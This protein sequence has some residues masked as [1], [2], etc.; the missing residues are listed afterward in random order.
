MRAVASI[1]L[2]LLAGCVASQV[3]RVSTRLTCQDYANAWAR[4]AN[5]RGIEAGVVWYGC[6]AGGGH[7]IC[8][9]IEPE[10]GD[11]VFVEPQGAY[12]VTL[13]AAEARSVCHWSWGPTVGRR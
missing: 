2:V 8:W 5:R 1:M 12:R 10:T 7:A 3:D 11:T 13:S 6:D 4:E 9:A